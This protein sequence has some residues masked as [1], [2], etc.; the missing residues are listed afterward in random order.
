MLTLLENALMSKQD[1]FMPVVRSGQHLP[2]KAEVAEMRELIKIDGY[3]YFKPLEAFRPDVP[4]T[5][6]GR[7][8]M[9]Q[10]VEYGNG[11]RRSV[12]LA[13]ISDPSTSASSTPT[14][15]SAGAP[16]LDDAP[17]PTAT[18]MDHLTSTQ[19]M[20]RLPSASVRAS[21][22]APKVVSDWPSLSE[23]PSTDAKDVPVIPRR[24]TS[25]GQ[26][27]NPE[28]GPTYQDS[29]DGG[30]IEGVAP[31]LSLREILEQEKHQGS[32]VQRAT[33][34]AITGASSTK[35]SKLSQKERRKLLQQQQHSSTHEIAHS[36]QPT[37]ALQAW[38]KMSSTTAADLSASGP[39][40]GSGSLPRTNSMQG[41]T[42]SGTP[43]LLE[44]QQGELALF[45][46]QPKDIPRVAIATSKPVKETL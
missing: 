42:S 17:Q 16:L 35:T 44:I 39:A 32:R 15:A 33:S 24:K 40:E 28:A 29:G 31:K 19:M 43:S 46:A 36:S 5:T 7:M 8:S 18:A 4:K 3:R 45:R 27:P 30:A 6:H 38:A 2:D 20:E 41:A 12:S 34:A 9:D 14:S 1:A 37:P 10:E 13:D 25:W 11:A 23:S 22:L 26:L 21:T